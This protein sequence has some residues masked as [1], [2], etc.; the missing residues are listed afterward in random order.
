MQKKTKRLIFILAGITVL[1]VVFI[2]VSSNPN[3]KLHSVYNVIGT[4]IRYIQ[5]G[6]TSLGRNIGGAFSVIG[7]YSEIQDKIQKLE[8]ENDSLKNLES[9]NEKLKEENE[10]I[11]E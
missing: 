4:P 2:A 8:E 5:K 1:L 7:D 6:F 9:E 10:A 3:S 11:S